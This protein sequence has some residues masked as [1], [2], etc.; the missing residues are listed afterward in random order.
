[1][2][3]LKVPVSFFHHPSPNKENKQVSSQLPE[4]IKARA[5]MA[6]KHPSNRLR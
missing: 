6:V 5:S 1:M 2:K 4:E 3:N